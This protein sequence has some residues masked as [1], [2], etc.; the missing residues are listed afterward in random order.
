MTGIIYRGNVTE[1]DQNLL[2]YE[3]P[4]GKVSALC[5]ILGVVTAWVDIT[6]QESKSLPDEFRNTPASTAEGHS[7]TLF[8]SLGT[9]VSTLS[10]PFTCMAENSTGPSDIG[11]LF[12][13]PDASNF[14]FLSTEYSTGPS[15]AGNFSQSVHF[16]PRNDVLS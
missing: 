11:A 1:T 4:I 5:S 6:T 2:L 3:N 15:G 12:Y 14:E 7:K 13:S 9:N 16:V 8:E 10:T